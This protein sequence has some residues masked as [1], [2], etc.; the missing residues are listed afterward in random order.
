MPRAM[1]TEFAHSRNAT[2]GT[3]KRAHLNPEIVSERGLRFAAYSIATKNMDKIENVVSSQFDLLTHLKE[4]WNFS[5]PD[6]I[7]L[8]R[9]SEDIEHAVKTFER[10]RSSLAYDMDGIVFKMNSIRAQREMGRTYLYLSI[11]FHMTMT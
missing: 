5:V 8:C 3:L 2:A 6:N 11:L 4:K 10:L 9:N 7:M 1:S